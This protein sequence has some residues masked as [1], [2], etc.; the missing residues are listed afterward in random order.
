MS[1]VGSAFLWAE[2]VE[3]VADF[4]PSFLDG[5]CI[6][7]AEEGFELGE[8]H[9]DRVEIWAVGREKEQMGSGGSDGPPG[10]G[11]LVAAEIVEDHDVPRLEGRHQTLLDPGCE[12]GRVDGAIEDAGRHDLALAQRTDE[13]Q[14]LPVSMRNLG[15]KRS[16]AQ[17]PAARPGH[18]CLDPGF[19]QEDEA[20]S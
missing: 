16:A 10:T 12:R 9:L 14:G 20:V 18:V 7:F 5:A 1:D 11:R 17:E 2:A 4:T 6:G 15:G 3:K 8:D 13:R 19:V